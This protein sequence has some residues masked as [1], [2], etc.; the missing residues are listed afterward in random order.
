MLNNYRHCFGVAVFAGKVDVVHAVAEP[1]NIQIEA[2][3]SIDVE[4]PCGLAQ[5]VDEKLARGGPRY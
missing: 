3:I 1:L 5:V 4:A 2:F